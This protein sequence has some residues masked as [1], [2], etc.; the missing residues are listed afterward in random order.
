MPPPSAEVRASLRRRDGDE[1][2]LARAAE[3]GRAAAPAEDLVVAPQARAGA[4]TELRAALAHDDH[5]R[6]DRL[7]GED[8]D[9]EPLRLGVA[10]VPRGAQTFLVSHLAVTFLVRERG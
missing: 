8:L 1:A 9:A 10:P 5:P 7:A 3:L 4:G 2:L 6:L